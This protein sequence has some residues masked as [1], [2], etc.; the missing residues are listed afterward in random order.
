ME[1]VV[2]RCPKIEGR[3][4]DCSGGHLLYTTDSQN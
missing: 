1:P 3:K 2:Q 4:L